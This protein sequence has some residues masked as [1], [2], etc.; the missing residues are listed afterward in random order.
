ML[1]PNPDG[2]DIETLRILT[3][4]E[5]MGAKSQV[6]ELTKHTGENLEL[7]QELM[8]EARVAA[9]NGYVESKGY[10]DGESVHRSTK[11]YP[12]IVKRLSSAFASGIAAA[13]SVAKNT[14]NGEQ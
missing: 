14:L 10:E 8:A 9:T 6:T 13:I 2:I 7:D 3:R 12:K 11:H 5:T 1:R 4:L